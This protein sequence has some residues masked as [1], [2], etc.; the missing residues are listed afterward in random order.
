M[1]AKFLASSAIVLIGLAEVT[2]SGAAWAQQTVPAAKPES[3]A[4]TAG[5]ETPIIGKDAGAPAAEVATDAPIFAEAAPFT[6]SG[7][8]GGMSADDLIGMNVVD[9][10]GESVGK[11][12]DVIIGS[13]DVVQHA[14][15]EIGGFLGFGAKTT[16][17][18]V[19]HASVDQSKG[20]VSLHITR[21]EIDAMSTYERDGNGWF[22]G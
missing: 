12:S 15:V 1:T 20:E 19:K 22:S 18:D 5:A 6:G 2:L 13:D 8:G 21:A 10:D 9:S 17:I 11:V 16:A 4:V 7:V 14:I 3:A